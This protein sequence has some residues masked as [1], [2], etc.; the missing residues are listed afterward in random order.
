MKIIN[1]LLSVVVLFLI[2]GCSEKSEIDILETMVKTESDLTEVQIK[3]TPGEI[4]EFSHRLFWAFA[5]GGRTLFEMNLKKANLEEVFIE[6][7]EKGSP[8]SD[9][10]D[11]PASDETV[12][13]EVLDE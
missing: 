2:S 10:E 13:E 11:N 9:I 6:L 3:T 5:E 1:I 12:M 4:Y 7:T 8:L